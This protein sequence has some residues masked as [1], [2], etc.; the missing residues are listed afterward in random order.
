MVMSKVVQLGETWEEA[1]R[2]TGTGEYSDALSRCAAELGAA[3]RADRETVRGV[4]ETAKGG[5][6]TLVWV[7]FTKD[8]SLWWRPN[9]RGYTPHLLAAGAY[10]EVEAKR[11]ASDGRA[12]E[13]LPIAEA[14]SR[15]GALGPGTVMSAYSLPTPTTEGEGT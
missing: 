6:A 9:A 2:E 11:L 12:D 13:A 4:R 10:T 8:C 15:T 14:L 7:I 5:D 3:I 1:A